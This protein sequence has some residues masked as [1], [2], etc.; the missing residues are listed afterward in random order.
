[1]LQNWAIDIVTELFVLID[2]E[3]VHELQESAREFGA[4]LYALSFS[5]QDNE[6]PQFGAEVKQNASIESIQEKNINLVELF[7]AG[8][9]RSKKAMCRIFPV[10]LFIPSELRAELMS[11]H[12]ASTCLKN[13]RNTKSLPHFSFDFDMNNNVSNTRNR[14][15]SL[16]VGSKNTTPQMGE[17]KVS[18]FT[19]TRF[20][21]RYVL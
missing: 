1:V 4:L 2:L 21:W 6:E 14:V 12:T 15:V 10:E 9:T 5:V 11:R 7:C 16:A 3:Q 8:N 13:T 18:L 20:Q 19:T 17:F